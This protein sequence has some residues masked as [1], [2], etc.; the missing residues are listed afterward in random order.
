MA[1]IAQ[2]NKKKWYH[3]LQA[4]PSSEYDLRGGD[5]VPLGTLTYDK[6]SLLHST[7]LQKPT[8]R[9]RNQAAHTRAKHAPQNKIFPDSAKTRVIYHNCHPNVVQAD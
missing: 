6:L 9:L 7:F 2:G 3:E 4:I 1:F 8:R 5:S